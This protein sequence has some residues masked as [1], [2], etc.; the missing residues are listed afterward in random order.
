MLFNTP[1][2]EAFA[3]LEMPYN[4]DSVD[5]RSIELSCSLLRGDLAVVVIGLQYRPAKNGLTALATDLKW[6]P[7]DIVDAA[8]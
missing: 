7:V 1:G 8:C 5:A 4:N 2:Q 6:L 3:E